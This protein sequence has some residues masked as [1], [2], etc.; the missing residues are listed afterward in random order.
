VAP[1]SKSY[2]RCHGPGRLR[3]AGP[4]DWWRDHTP[5]SGG[6]LA[7]AARLLESV[8]FLLGTVPGPVRDRVL[9]R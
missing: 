7:D 8:G 9:G 1:A 3:V 2:L 6:L 4:L 5:G